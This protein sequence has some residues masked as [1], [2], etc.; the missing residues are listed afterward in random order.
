MQTFT[1]DELTGWLQKNMGYSYFGAK[2]MSDF[3]FKARTTGA[4]DRVSRKRRARWAKENE[5]FQRK[6]IK[7]AEKEGNKDKISIREMAEQHQN[8]AKP[9]G[10]HSSRRSKYLK[11]LPS[12]EGK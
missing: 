2:V 12:W 1:Q 6:L 7:E 4:K 5:G 3:L 11:D 9:I 10:E 8:R